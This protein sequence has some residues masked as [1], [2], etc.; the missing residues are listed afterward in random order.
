MT[1]GQ[2]PQ[3][4]GSLGLTVVGLTRTISRLEETG[5][6]SKNNLVERMCSLI[7]KV[8]NTTSKISGKRSP[9]LV[10]IRKTFCGRMDGQTLWLALL[11]RLRT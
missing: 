1:R 8:W 7:K 4:A 3:S 2:L 6:T 9:N 10:E 5:W 11:G